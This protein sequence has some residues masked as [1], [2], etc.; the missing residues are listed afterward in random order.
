[1][2][3]SVFM[4]ASLLVLIGCEKPEEEYY[5][6]DKTTTGILREHLAL[7]T[8]IGVEESTSTVYIPFVTKHTTVMAPYTVTNKE[9]KYAHRPLSA[10]QVVSIPTLVKERNDFCGFGMD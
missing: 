10:E 3:R 7:K 2:L 6:C 8:P 4:G 1:M 5:M 9:I